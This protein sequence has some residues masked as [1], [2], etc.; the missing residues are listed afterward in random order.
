MRKILALAF[1]AALA[2]GASSGMAQT[3]PKKP[4]THETLWM[5]KRVGAPVVSPDGKWVVFSV[6]EPAYKA[7]EAVQD[8]WLVPADGSAGPRRLT[9]TKGPESDPAWSPDS[10]RLAFSAK[11]EGDEVP[12]VYILDLAGG[13]A[14]RVTASATGASRPKWRP[15]GG[16]ILFEAIGYPGAMDDGADKKAA[17]ERKARKYNVR[18]YSHFPVRYWNE[19]IDDKRPSLWVQ[20]LSD[21]AKASDILSPSKLA[22]MQGFGGQAQGDGGTSLDALWSPDGKEVIFTATTE[23]WNAAFARV[24]YHLYRMPAEGGEP[25][26]ITPAGQYGNA[27]FTPDGKTLLFVSATEDDQVYNLAH[28]NRIAWPTGGAAGPVTGDFDR[29][30][31]DYQISPDSKTAYLLVPDAGH[32]NL[33]RVPVAGGKPE[34]VIAPETGG[35]TALDIPE[36]AKGLE[37]IGTFASSVS[38]AE[39][40]RIDPAKHGHANLTNIDT[41][42]AAAIDWSPPQHFWTTSAKGRKIHS[43]LFTPPGFDPARKYPLLVII[44]GG[45][46]SSNTDQISLRWNYHLLAAPGYVVLVTDYTGSTGYGE[47]F[48]QAIKLDPLR[49]PADEINQAADEAVKKYPF[50]DGSRMCAG[51]ASYGGHLSNWLEAT[52]TTRYKCLISH[53]GE[54]D[55]ATQWGESDFN[56]GREIASGGPPWAGN[57]VWKDQ[58]PLAYGDKWKTPMLLSVGERDFR[59]PIGNTLENWSTLQRM[60]VPSRLMVWPDAWHWI[61]KPED[62]RQF[63]KEVHMWLGHY[64]LDGPAPPDSEPAQP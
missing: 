54:V 64:L 44:H 60:Q 32:E 21:G 29:E 30:V 7:D 23:R 38:P 3:A 26:E 27:A 2:A 4:I 12:Q 59:V 33:Y 10:G 24:G 48:A 61:L 20:P 31:A 6:N 19:W 14:H 53:A 50:I 47:A 55:L 41:A 28:L 16:A 37:L 15:D 49:T 36:K 45:P 46:A 11:R 52:N 13:E 56:Y 9:S 39:V 18:I 35:Y 58:S 34:L 22:Q 40:V 51:G 17:D 43:M 63:Y 62:S 57:P 8:L 5:M 42:A 25:K 1:I